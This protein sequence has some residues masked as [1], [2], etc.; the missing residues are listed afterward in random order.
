M[1]P[2]KVFKEMLPEKS[3]QVEKIIEQV[4][5]GKFVNEPP[6]N[7]DLDTDFSQCF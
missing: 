6:K 4:C 5:S 2:N 1:T 7:T 3:K